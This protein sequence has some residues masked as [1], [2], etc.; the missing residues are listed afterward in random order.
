MEACYLKNMA[1]PVMIM[2]LAAASL[3][4]GSAWVTITRPTNTC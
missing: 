2:H 3:G 1:T 4:L